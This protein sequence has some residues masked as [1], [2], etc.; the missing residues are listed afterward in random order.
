MSP[1]HG[2]GSSASAGPATGV[3]GHPAG[4]GQDS[5]TGVAGHPAG[6]EPDATRPLT[7]M[8]REQQSAAIRDNQLSAAIRDNV[9]VPQAAL[10]LGNFMGGM[11]ASTRAAESD[12]D[13]DGPSSVVGG[14]PQSATGVLM[15]EMRVASKGLLAAVQEQQEQHEQH[16]QQLQLL[17][18]QSQ[19]KQQEQQDRWTSYQQQAEQVLRDQQQHAIF[20]PGVGTPLVT[21]ERTR[22]M[23]EQLAGCRDLM[24][25]AERLEEKQEQHRQQLQLLRDKQQQLHEQQQELQQQQQQQPQANVHQQRLAN[26]HRQLL[27]KRQQDRAESVAALQAIV[28]EEKIAD[29]DYVADQQRQKQQRQQP[30]YP[31]AEDGSPSR[32]WEETASEASP[33]PPQA[34]T[35]AGAATSRRLFVDDP[36]DWAD[37]MQRHTA[38]ESGRCLGAT[39]E[40]AKAMRDVAQQA[41]TSLLS[42]PAVAEIPNTLPEVRLAAE[43]VLNATIPLAPAPRVAAVPPVF[44]TTAADVE[45]HRKRICCDLAAASG[46]AELAAMRW[47][48]REPDGSIGGSHSRRKHRQQP[49]ASAKTR[50]VLKNMK[51][52]QAIKHT[53]SA[54]KT[55]KGFKKQL[56]QTIKAFKKQL[57]EYFK[58]QLHEYAETL[59]RSIH[60]ND[61]LGTRFMRYQWQKTEEKKAEK[62]KDSDFLGFYADLAWR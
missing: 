34:S 9:M 55:I 23:S 49:Q 58:N 5:A 57:H 62:A 44:A 17:R 24:L 11:L 8:E 13:N 12:S 51:R 1:N 45:W 32:L 25:A 14:V 38:A 41:A 10:A 7:I 3:A 31:P 30:R 16:Q 46:P 48:W 2:P 47:Q 28:D 61:G 27:A 22:L 29:A 50:K 56:P 37:E 15:T 60:F 54:L 36:L 43:S 59:T 18:D 42:M 26:V 21:S 4:V 35:A 33:S 39:L 52:M 40:A 20:A 53:F 19:R 6:V